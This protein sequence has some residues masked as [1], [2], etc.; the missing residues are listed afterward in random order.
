MLA[1]T[2]LSSEPSSQTSYLQNQW[3]SLLSFSVN[4]DGG[5]PVVLAYI[6][7]LLRRM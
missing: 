2:F 4:Q 1:C 6:R 5:S 7:V 3:M